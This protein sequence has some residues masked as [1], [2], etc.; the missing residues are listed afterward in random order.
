M[1]TR[2][3]QDFSLFHTQWQEMREKQVACCF[4]VWWIASGL[5]LIW[6]F[7]IRVQF[8]AVVAVVVQDDCEADA[9]SCKNCRISGDCIR[10][11]VWKW[12]E[13]KCAVVLLAS[14]CGCVWEW[15]SGME[16]SNKQGNE[17]EL[18]V[19]LHTP[20]VVSLMWEKK[21]TDC[22]LPFKRRRG[23]SCGT[24]GGEDATTGLL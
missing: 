3:R 12:E 24:R 13:K 4:S 6:C 20:I 18:C 11:C 15:V 17:S 2:S 9:A 23:S 22:S 21:G 14:E 8:D 7:A 1:W 16:T 19:C 10:A 5:N